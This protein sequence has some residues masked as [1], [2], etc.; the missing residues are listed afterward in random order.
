VGTFRHELRP[1]PISI[2]RA[3]PWHPRRLIFVDTESY[4][5][6][7]EENP[8][9]KTH[10]LRLWCASIVWLRDGAVTMRESTKGTDS[11]SFWLW[12]QRILGSR[13]QSW[14]YA[15]NLGY[16][17]HMLDFWKAV[18]RGAISLR[19]AIVED[20]P[21]IIRCTLGGHMLVACDTLNYWRLPLGV[22]GEGLGCTKLPMPA[23]SDSSIA[24]CEYCQRDVEIV[25]RA[26][27]GLVTRTAQSQMCRWAPTAAGLSWGCFLAN[28][29]SGGIY[30]HDDKD[31]TK[32]ERGSYY[33][34]R[35][36]C[37]TRGRSRGGV[38]VLDVNSLYP[39]V[40]RG[41]VYPVAL[42]VC[43]TCPTADSVRQGI[44]DHSIMAVVELLTKD[45]VYPIRSQGKVAYAKGK[46]TTCLAGPELAIAW[47]RGDLRSIFWAAHYNVQDIFT[48]FVNHF[49]Q[50]RQ[51]ARSAGDEAGGL[52]DKLIL[53]SLHGK[54]GQKGCRWVPAKGCRMPHRWG[55]W[56]EID[57]ERGSRK[58]YRGIAG[59]IQEQEKETE[60]VHACPAISG[61]VT[62][63]A[64]GYMQK[65]FDLLPDDDLYYSD[66]D[67]LHVS[68][69]G[70]D[71][72]G[73]QGLIDSTEL[74][75][76]KT[77][78]TCD[79][80]EYIA[81]KAYVTPHRLVAAGLRES[82]VEVAPG[83]WQQESWPGLLTTLAGGPPSTYQTEVV[84]RRVRQ[85]DPLGH[86][87]DAQVNGVFPL[88]G[89]THDSLR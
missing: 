3:T 56:V 14:I 63:Y 26:V 51:V 68:T 65:L 50:R 58:S 86:S 80:I 37:F 54:F 7:R 11:D 87:Q 52:L 20:P 17:L 70:A 46:F 88:W 59:V 19:S 47:N 75:K 13:G 32:I 22:L 21:T 2:K 39:S 48:G 49:W 5:R 4:V 69:Y 15:H 30:V 53:N 77:E 60:W 40:M 57:M 71:L 73:R 83:L 16:D 24:W 8:N 27:V 31:V 89:K 78:A 42:R 1:M 23:Q 66:T 18:E 72:F 28:F 6:P 41:N 25:E 35:V 79:W 10:H 81:P 55:A 36:A 44:Q 33:G 45:Q 38:H 62:S 12:I 67:S 82:A 84:S 9:V 61:W 64:R 74:G 76:L 29:Y 34:G 85:L 43:D